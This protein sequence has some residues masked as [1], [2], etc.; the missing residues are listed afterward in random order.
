MRNPL[1][2]GFEM[3]LLSA[4][5][6]LK[7]SS[8]CLLAWPEH[9]NPVVEVSHGEFQ[10][11][12]TLY[13]LSGRSKVGDDAN[14]TT[15][16]EELEIVVSHVEVDTPPPVVVTD[17][18]MHD[19]T[20]RA[21]YL[22]AKLPGFQ[23]AAH[24]IAN[25]ILL[26]FRFSLFTPLVRPIAAWSQSLQNPKW[27]DADGV[28]V[29]GGSIFMVLAVPGGRGEL[30]AK[31]LSPADLPAL[32][33]F[34]S[35]TKE[36]PLTLELLSD[37]QSAWFEGNLRRCILELAICTEVMVKRIYFAKAS[38]SGAAF[39]YLE[40]KAKVSVRVLELM[41]AVA[42]EAFSISYKD[43]KPAHFQNIDHL[44]RCRNKIAHRGELSFRDDSGKVID[45]GAPIVEAWWLAVADLKLWL[46]SLGSGL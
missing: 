31:K 24:E 44:F 14:W 11:V 22:R 20:F 9:Q 42:K 12:A 36:I 18:G 26:F 28:E 8:P 41:D 43:E 19:L 17:D 45:V 35:S 39:D 7:I 23:N 4:Q 2:L 29:R 10:V 3:H 33:S 46:E 27:F 13:S 30:G 40:D 34:V 21:E 25:R 32:K 6:K 37:A 15:E 5:F 38:P 1:N 16:L